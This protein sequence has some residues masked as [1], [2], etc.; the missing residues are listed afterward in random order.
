MPRLVYKVPRYTKHVSGR[1][2]VRYNGKSIYLGD[3]GSPESYEAYAKFVATIPKP[4]AEGA[5]PEIA[6]GTIPLIG[7]M[8]VHYH[9]HARRYYVRPDGAQTGEADTIRA[10]LRP[11]KKMFGE[12]P[13]TEF[14]P[15][16]FK[17][18]QQA[19]IQ[20]DWSRQYVNKASGIIKRCFLWCASEELIPASVA[21]GLKTV[22]G[23][24]KGRTAARERAKIGPVADETI[25]ATIPHLSA[26]A[27][28][29]VRLM[30]RTGA[31]PGEALGMVASGIDRT[32]PECWVY[33]PDHHKTEH[34]GKGRSIYIGPDA[35]QI[36]LPR[37]MKA[38]DDGK[39][40]PMRRTTLC[41]LVYR[42]C[43]K[44]F[45]HAELSAIPVSKL[46][47]AERAELKAWDKAHR[48]HP[49]M[50]RHTFGT[51]V[52]AKYGL[53][54]AQVLLGHSR[55]DVTQV[56]AERDVKKAQDVARKIG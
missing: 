7:E 10:V 35:Q 46:T 28:D 51:E 27:A 15:K 50:I 19:M 4:E 12:L 30:R 9:A 11:L 1:A 6:P 14:G 25:E 31:R 41:S 34:H 22:G 40:F 23:L 29:V 21:V 32:D 44:A 37:L 49:N 42:A 47:A 18:L 24:K 43:R 17:Q 20:L 48:W 53:E 39:L 52:R 36:I 45:P 16:K 5:P 26:L 54:A 55:A 8:C 13:A 3:Y 56:Y 33:R 38:G 2:R